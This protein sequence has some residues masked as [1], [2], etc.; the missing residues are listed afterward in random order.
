[1]A[2]NYTWHR[3]RLASRGCKQSKE[4]ACWVMC[5][6]TEAR[7]SPQLLCVSAGFQDVS[8]AWSALCSDRLWWAVNMKEKNKSELRCGCRSNSLWLPGAV[9]GNMG[10]NHFPFLKTL[11]LH[12]HRHTHTTRGRQCPLLSFLSSVWGV[13]EIGGGCCF[14]RCRDLN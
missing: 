4:R 2:I 10:M 6:R 7:S 13:Y 9:D 5:S 8:V 11:Y 14:L 1:M 3:V 12:S